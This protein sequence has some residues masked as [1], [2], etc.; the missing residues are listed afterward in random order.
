[1]ASIGVTRPKNK[2]Y[3]TNLLSNPDNPS[4][5]EGSAPAGTSGWLGAGHW[6]LAAN[7]LQ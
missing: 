5:I 2:S 4:G 6:S 7:A 1:M 3:R